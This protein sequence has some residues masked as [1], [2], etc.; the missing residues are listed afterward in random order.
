MCTTLIAVVGACV[1]SS[2]I[3]ATLRSYHFSGRLFAVGC[4]TVFRCVVTGHSNHPAGTRVLVVR[5]GKVLR[6]VTPTG[7]DYG[8]NSSVSCPGRVGCIAALPPAGGWGVVLATVDAGGRITTKRASAPT[9]VVFNSISCATLASCELVGISANGGIA[10]ATW[11]GSRRGRL[12]YAIP[13]PPP[14]HTTYGVGNELPTVSCSAFQCEVVL[15]YAVDPLLHDAHQAFL[16]HLRHGR[17]DRSQWA[18]GVAVSSAVV[19]YEP[20]LLGD[21]HRARRILRP[22]ADHN[23]QRRAPNPRPARRAR[24]V[25]RVQEL[26]LRGSRRRPHHHLRLR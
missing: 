22:S 11:N 9:G 18:S 6:S 8:N 4:E 2:G 26:H 13:P 14:G 10:M 25:A 16:V 1:P 23:R 24:C 12:T 15:N 19:R 7:T 20:P 3:A 21:R 17:I 5:N